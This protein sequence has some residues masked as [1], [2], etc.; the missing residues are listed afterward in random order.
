MDSTGEIDADP[1]FDRMPGMKTDPG[2]ETTNGAMPLKQNP[3]VADKLRAGIRYA[4][5]EVWGDIARWFFI[6][7]F[8]AGA[9]SALIP[10]GFFANTFGSGWAVMPAMLVLGAPLYICATSSTPL[11]A[12]MIAKGLSPGAALVF[13]L[14]GPA[15]NLTSLSVVAGFL[16][17]RTAVM[18]VSVIAGM[19]L[20][21]GYA[22]DYLYRVFSIPPPA[23]IG[24]RAQALPAGLHLAGVIVLSAWTLFIIARRPGRNPE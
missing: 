18:Y 10:A 3:P 13:L 23:A 2:P 17:R 11:A 22:V 8:A 4:V 21:L 20:L 19:S 14:A 7:L 9:V 1:T 24:E 12:A 15:T 16:G 5:T 6:G